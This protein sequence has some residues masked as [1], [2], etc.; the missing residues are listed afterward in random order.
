MRKR[1]VQKIYTYKVKNLQNES[2]EVPK[3]VNYI[4]Y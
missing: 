2:K 4:N 3:F 1:K